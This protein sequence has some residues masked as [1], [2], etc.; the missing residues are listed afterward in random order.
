MSKCETSDY[1]S[2]EGGIWDIR[3]QTNAYYDNL[4]YAV[5][6]IINHCFCSKNNK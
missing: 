6:Q 2:C 5:I 4:V 3:L 1:D